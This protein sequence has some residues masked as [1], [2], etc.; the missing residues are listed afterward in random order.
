M[1][2]TAA[3]GDL[4][5]VRDFVNSIAIE[6]GTDPLS[7]DGALPEWCG[8]T[9]LCPD[10]DQSSLRD[11]REFREALRGVL[12]ANAGDGEAAERWRA[13][14]PFAGRA[15]YSMYITPAGV[16]A[17][18][19][20]G[21][22]ADAA[23]AAVL[24]IVY[25]AIGNGTWPRLKACRKHSCRWAFYDKSKNGSGAWCSMQVCGNRAKAERRR[26]REKSHGLQ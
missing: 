4:E 14:E 7:E 23:I 21:S 8:R 26:A 9:G 19:A 24:A 11:L 17:L 10:A 2:S 22:G 20:R 25:D 6:Q 13:L 15:G 16:P 12:E 18:K 5:I 3:P 1:A